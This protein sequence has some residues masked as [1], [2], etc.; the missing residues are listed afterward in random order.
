MNGKVQRMT[1]RQ[2]N[3]SD[4]PLFITEEIQAEMEAQ[5]YTFDPPAHVSTIRLHTIL[6]GLSDEE[7]ARWPELLTAQEWAK[8]RLRAA[9]D[10]RPSSINETLDAP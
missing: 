2:Q 6:A 8:R 5:G 10:G 7:L 1:H 4:Q 9:G 3:D